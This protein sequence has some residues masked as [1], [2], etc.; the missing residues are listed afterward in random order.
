M[1]V[2]MRQGEVAAVPRAKGAGAV[3]LAAGDQTQGLDVRPRSEHVAAIAAV[4]A[5][6]E[7]K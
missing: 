7:A 5:G 3:H 1:V 4:R 2:A 6:A